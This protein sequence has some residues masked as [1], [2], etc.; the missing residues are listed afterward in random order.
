MFDVWSYTHGMKVEELHLGKHV[1]E[2]EKELYNRW[3]LWAFPAPGIPRMMLAVCSKN[4]WDAKNCAASCA[5][6]DGPWACESLT[7]ACHFNSNEWVTLDLLRKKAS[8]KKKE[9]GSL[10]PKQS[11]FDHHHPWPTHTPRAADTEQATWWTCSSALQRL[12]AILYPQHLLPKAATSHC[13]M[14][15]LALIK[16][17]Y[18]ESNWLSLYLSRYRLATLHVN[19]LNSN[20]ALALAS[21][22]LTWLPSSQVN[23]Q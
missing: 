4:T 7:A 12:A 2:D 18:L 15:G 21:P 1:K 3:T 16:K 11:K 22:T 17:D 23:F 5:C 9:I 20:L 10:C 6:L 8:L 13:L 14:I 19:F